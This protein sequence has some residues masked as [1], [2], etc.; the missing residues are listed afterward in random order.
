MRRESDDLSG[1]GDWAASP[2]TGP[3][4]VEQPR[5]RRRRRRYRAGWS[6][7]LAA[8]ANSAVGLA[9]IATGSTL[10]GLV[11]T[12][13][14]SICSLGL[15][16]GELLAQRDAEE[17]SLSGGTPRRGPAGRRTTARWPDSIR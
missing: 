4:P 2:V 14:I 7:G 9:A 11:C 3:A 6:L 10:I 12:I 1:F 5:R 13:T 15:V 8:T 17:K 16:A